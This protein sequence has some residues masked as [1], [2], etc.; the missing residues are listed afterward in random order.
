MAKVKEL[1]WAD[2]SSEKETM[3][4]IK[5]MYD[6]YDYLVDTHTAVAIDVYDKYVMSTGDMTKA[7]IASTASP[8]KFNNSVVSALF[9]E[10][11]FKGK[12]EFE[13]LELLSKH[14]KLEIPKGLKDLDKKEIK[15]TALCRKNE[16]KKQVE[17]IL[18]L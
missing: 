9:E 4:T 2:F 10:D 17:N 12:N 13:L 14:C 1:F 7:I 18:G 6:D 16:M 11:K 15:H 3:E 5:C 8:F